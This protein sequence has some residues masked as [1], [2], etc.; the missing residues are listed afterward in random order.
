MGV[1]Q[2]WPLN[3]AHWHLV[4]NHLPIVGF[5]FA[6][7]VL[8]LS[9]FSACSAWRKVG[10]FITFVAAAFLYPVFETGEHAYDLVK[11]L[12]GVAASQI[13]RHAEKAILAIWCAGITGGLALLAFIAE[14][15]KGKCLIRPF[16]FLIL[17]GVFSSLLFFAATAYEGGLIRHPELKEQTKPA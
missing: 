6:F 11:K 5:V 12:E 15:V 10:W 13:D 2:G 4:V 8:A 17:L 3:A 1:V 14:G 16:R 7:L 9:E